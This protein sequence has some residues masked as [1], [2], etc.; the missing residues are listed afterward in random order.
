MTTRH[1][2]GLLG[3]LGM[4]GAGAFFAIYGSQYTMGTAARM[5]AG[6]FP[7]ILGWIL[8]ALG[9]L[10]ALPACWRRGEAVVVQWSNLIWSVLGVVAFA[11]MLKAVGVVVASF[12]TCLITLMPARMALRLRLLVSAVIA[13]LTTLTFVIGLRMTLPIWP[14]QA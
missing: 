7:A 9:L 4:A 13:G 8:V 3:G 5:G 12:A 2:H 11:A 1:I 14:W 6:F 10:I